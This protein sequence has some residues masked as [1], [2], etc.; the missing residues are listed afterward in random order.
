MTLQQL[1]VLLGCNCREVVDC[2]LHGL[3]VSC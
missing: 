3:K 2:L 1:L